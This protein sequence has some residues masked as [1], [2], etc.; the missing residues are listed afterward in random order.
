MVIKIFLNKSLQ[1]E[2]LVFLAFRKT[3]KAYL[4]FFPFFMFMSTCLIY[5]EGVFQGFFSLFFSS[6]TFT[7]NED[8]MFLQLCTVSKTF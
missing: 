8:S 5:V 6:F 1:R 7:L 3:C 2:A 4:V